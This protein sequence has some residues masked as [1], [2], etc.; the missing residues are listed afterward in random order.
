MHGWALVIALI[1][2]L[3]GIAGTF[4]PVLPGVPLVFA[5]IAAYG[6]YDGFQTVTPKYLAIIAGVTVLSLF[7]DYISTYLGAKYFGSSKM[8]LYGAV[9]GSFVGLFIFPP[10]GLLIGPWIGAIIGE[11]MQGNDWK[12]ASR[13]GLG[14]VV[15]LFSGIAF[16]VILASVMLASF[17][18]IIF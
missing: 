14:A 8:G 13:S 7:V 3:I 5:A 10:A 15:G 6:W 4:I 9:I 16:K 18:I 17:L 1:V 2:I 12:K 11:Y